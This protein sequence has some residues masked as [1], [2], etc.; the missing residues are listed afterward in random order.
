[1]IKPTEIRNM[2]V[3][4][5]LDAILPYE[6]VVEKIETD[7]KS[8]YILN[9]GYIQFY[10]YELSAETIELLRNEGF[11]VYSAQ[12]YDGMDSYYGYRVYWKKPLN[13]VQQLLSLFV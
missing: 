1:M 11:F 7:I 2:E 3:Q 13:I 6:K 10:R 5:K 9:K 8:P 4:G 12:V